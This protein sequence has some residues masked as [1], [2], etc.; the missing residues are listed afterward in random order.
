VNEALD[1]TLRTAEELELETRG[2]QT[3]RAHRVTVW[4]AYDPPFVWLRTDRER[5]WFLNLE[6][7]P[8]C[9][10][11][12]GAVSADAIRTAVYDDPAS[13]RRAVELWRAKYGAEWVADWYFEHGRAVVQLRLTSP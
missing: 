12:V 2:R 8:H 13:L 7:D 6:G 5:D 3:G 1:A 11:R 10:I 4:F 9:R